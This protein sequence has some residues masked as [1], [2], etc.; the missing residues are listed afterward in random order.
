M[1]T[2]LLLIAVSSILWYLYYSCVFQVSI[3][4]SSLSLDLVNNSKRYVLNSIMLP[5]GFIAMSLLSFKWFFYDFAI[6]P[7][8]SMMPNFS[9]GQKILLDKSYFGLRYPFDNSII[10]NG[11]EPKRGQVVVTQ[12]PKN[13]QIM[14][15]KR[16]IGLPGDHISLNEH[17]LKINE[18]AYPLISLG[19]SELTIKDKTATYSLYEIKVND[20]QWVYMVDSDKQFPEILP[21]EVPEKGYYLLGDNLTGSSDSRDFGPIPIDYFM[22]SII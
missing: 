2:Y 3:A 10:V 5:A 17:F 1:N 12:F 21:F 7:S 19:E 16:V 4:K 22:A 18:N 11:A 6:I 9:I 15:L 8:A 20:N 14:Y 13:P